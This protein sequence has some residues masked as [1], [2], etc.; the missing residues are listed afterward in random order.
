MDWNGTLF[1][2]LNPEEQEDF[3]QWARDNYTPLSP[4][5][6]VWHPAV[7]RECTRINEEHTLSLSG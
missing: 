3:K 2:E 5:K 1:R 7:Q 6:G 4:I